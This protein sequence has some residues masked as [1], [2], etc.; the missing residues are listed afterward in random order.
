MSVVAIDQC[1][2]VPCV[3]VGDDYDLPTGI[4]RSWSNAGSCDK[5]AKKKVHRGA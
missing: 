2:R 4:R 1:E 5:E 3:S